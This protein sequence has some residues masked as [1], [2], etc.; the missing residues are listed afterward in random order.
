MLHA[1]ESPATAEGEGA[2]VAAALREWLAGA[3]WPVG[4]P[5][6]VE[7]PLRWI[8]PN[9]VSSTDRHPYVL[10]TTTLLYPPILHITQ[11]GNVLHRQRLHTAVPNRPIRLT[12]RWNGRVDPTGGPVTVKVRT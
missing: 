2:H 6:A 9:R 7:P 11:N 3:D 12:A 8:A 4:V 1:V 5:L 10:R